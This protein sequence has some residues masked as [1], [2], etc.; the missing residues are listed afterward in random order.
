MSVVIILSAVLLASTPNDFVKT[1]EDIVGTEEVVT[2]IRNYEL[3]MTTIVYVQNEEGVWDEYQRLHGEENRIWVDIKE[4]PQELIDAFIA[5]EDQRFYDH[6]G[7]DWKRTASAFLNY[8]PFV[9]IYKSNQGGSTITQQL[10]KNITDDRSKSVVRKIREI[11]RALTVEKR[12]T[13]EKILEAYLNTISLGNG[14]CGVQVAANYYFNKDVSKLSLAECA[15]IAAITKNPVKYNPDTSPESNAK[16]RKSVLDKMLDLGKINNEEYTKAVESE[17]VVDK[18]QQSHFEIPINNYFIDTM[19]GDIAA[20]LAEKK[21]ITEEAATRL[22]Y[23][24]GY[25][26]Y[27]T[28]DREI[29]GKMEEVFN[30]KDTYFPL[31]SREDSEISMQ[32]A[33]TVLDYDG[34]I[35]GIVGG[36]GEKT[37]N[38]GLNRAIDSPRQPGSTMKPLG[39]YALAIDRGI[40]GYSSVVEDKP[41][42]NYYGWGQSGPR[43]WYG[44]YEG[45]IPLRRAIAHSANTIPVKYI[46]QIGLED[47]YAFLKYDLDLSFLD[48]GDINPASLAIGGCQYGITTTQSAAAYSIFGNH[49]VFNKPK[50][51]IKVL[52]SNG[53]TVL[54]RNEGRQVL[55]PEAADIMNKL[56]Q[57]V[58]YDTGG[59]GGALAGY[60]GMRA[61]A[62]TGTSSEANDSW[63]VGGSPYYIASVWCG[64]DQPENMWNTRYASTIWRTV[65]SDIH[66]GLEYKTFEMTGRVYMSKFCTNTG[67]RAGSSCKDTEYGYCV[68][69]VYYKTCNGVHHKPKSEED[70]SDDTSSKKKSS[71]K[72]KTESDKKKS[73]SS[74]R[75]TSSSRNNSSKNNSSSSSRNNSSSTRSSVSS[76]VN[77]S[78]ANPPSSSVDSPSGT[79][80]SSSG[81]HSSLPDTSDSPSGAENT[82]SSSAIQSSDEP[83]D[84]ST[85]TVSDTPSS[86]ATQQDDSSGDTS[87]SETAHN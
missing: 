32:G 56:L 2:N 83:V 81:T 50:T 23:N 31:K 53:E 13:K 9:K 69:G 47:S 38:R 4:V 18:S 21:D 67:Y 64:F 39:V 27:A 43:E 62:K 49:G 24:G 84:S 6:D 29:Q 61:F 34:S 25:R 17:V 12:L 44:T 15:S 8:L 28:V 16:R 11:A 46:N 33:M 58:I 26:I 66:K 41:V 65:M 40:L 86:A 79:I 7:V 80:N 72:K 70:S 51:Y 82:P 5:I 1:V 75:N 54:E 48:E 35:K 73:S 71:D 87:S 59:T 77:S 42:A 20:D 22:L 3:N 55:K 76:R 57:G 60:S 45:W 14:I 10:I 78:S 68:P 37:I 74:K 19:I 36:A 85:N 30:D 52:D 63:V